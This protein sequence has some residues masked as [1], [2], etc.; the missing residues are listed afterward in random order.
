MYL[1]IVTSIEQCVDLKTLTVEDLVGRFKADDARVHV[2]TGKSE[3]SEQLMLTRQQWE[4]QWK[5][6]RGGPSK[7][8]CGDGKK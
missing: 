3:D 2:D 6:H 5:E 8:S 1:Q 7:P 4:A